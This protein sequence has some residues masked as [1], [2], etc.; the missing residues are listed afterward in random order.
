MKAVG[1]R[2][3]SP[4]TAADS[5]VDIDIAQP[6]ARGRDLLVE[7]KAVSVNPVDYKVRRSTA[8]TDTEWKVLGWD[9]AGIVRAAGADAKLFRPGDAVFYAGAIGRPGTNAQLHLVDERIVGHKPKSLDWAAS[10]ALPLTAITAWE[11]LFDRLDVRREV[12]G[13]EPSILIIGAGGGVGSIAIQLARQLTPLRVIGTASRAETKDWVKQLGAHDVIDHSTSLVS[14]MKA[15]GL[16]AP[17]FVYSTTHT[18]QHF[19]DIAELIAPQGRIVLI[20][21]LQNFDFM[22]LKRKS[23]SLHHELMFTRSIFGTPDMNEQGKLLNQVADLV[24]RNVIKTTLTE[25]RGLITAENLK[26]AHQTL[27]S[28]QARGKIVFEGF[29]D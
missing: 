9:A 21:E 11:G 16:A 14:G 8:P 28:G 26:R 19:A 4:I 1:Y 10:A 24:D 29:A 2:L 17:A 13:A 5:L 12:P 27:E 6:V 18:Q 15:L 23:V 22:A 3:P 7:V 20:D 25:N